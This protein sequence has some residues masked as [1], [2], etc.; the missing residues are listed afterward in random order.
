M[1]YRLDSAAGRFEGIEAMAFKDF[2]S[3]G[4]FEKDLEDLIAGNI[5]EVLFEDGSLTPI[6]QQRMG[7]PVVDIYAL[8]EAGDLTIVELKRSSAGKGAVHQ[9]L[10][11]AQDAGQWS[12]GDLQ[13]RY[14]QYSDSESDMDLVEAHQEAFGL[15]KT[16]E[17]GK[18]NRRQHLVVIGS[19]AD[20]SLIGA[21]DY[22]RR[23]GI[24]IRF[25]PYRI[26]DLDG[27]QYFEFFAE[28]YDRHHNPADEKGVLFD[29]A[30]TYDEDSIWYMMEKI[31]SQ[32]S[33]MRSDS[34]GTSTLATS[35]CFRTDVAESLRLRKFDPDG[36]A[37]TVPRHSTGTSSSLRQFIGSEA[38]FRRCH[39]KE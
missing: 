22:W 4:Q 30:Q 28:P 1:L 32:H 36:S 7:E 25:L 23:Q 17:A 26:Y 29:K 9:M 31:G 38:N 24:S 37:Q 12:H 2:A 20:D 6:Y 15:D 35:C 8:N 39:L 27:K 13:D 21:V 16:L 33:G 19:G 3:F 14:C 18:V 5:L 10:R 11:Y 34:L